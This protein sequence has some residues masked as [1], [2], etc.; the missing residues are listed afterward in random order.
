[1]EQADQ[2][3]SDVGTRVAFASDYSKAADDCLAR[4]NAAPVASLP[5]GLTP[6]PAPPKPPT[7]SLPPSLVNSIGTRP[8]PQ[9]SPPPSGGGAGW[10][11]ASPA[12]NGAEYA[13]GASNSSSRVDYAAGAGEAERLGEDRQ[14]GR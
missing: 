9:H 2:I 12:G 7:S 4:L 14:G 11:P 1:M 3:I 6:S 10:R 13:A 5:P 8:E